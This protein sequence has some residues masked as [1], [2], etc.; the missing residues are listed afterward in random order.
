MN[1]LPPP[2]DSHGINCVGDEGEGGM[3]SRVEEWA[4]VTS[5]PDRVYSP[6]T[7]GVLCR[8]RR[9]KIHTINIME[10]ETRTF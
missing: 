1:A 4:P 10:K 6:L 2:A 3:S 5:L 7:Y 8:A 9:G